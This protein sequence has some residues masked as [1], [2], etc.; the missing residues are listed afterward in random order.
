MEFQAVKY[1]M[2]SFCMAFLFYH[3]SCVVLS[4]TV[5]QTSTLYPT[6]KYLSTLTGKNVSETTAA[7][8]VSNVRPEDYASTT[9]VP[10]QE[11]NVLGETSKPIPIM[12]STYSSIMSS[13]Y[14]SGPLFQ[15]NI[16]SPECKVLET[17][18][19][20]GGLSKGF[21]NKNCY[22]D[23][24]CGSRNDCCKNYNPRTN[25]T[26]KEKQYS[27]VLTKSIRNYEGYGIY[28]VTSCTPPTVNV[29]TKIELLF[30][31]NM[32]QFVELF[33]HLNYKS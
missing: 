16:D 12:S 5:N 30:L 25:L 14:T 2:L 28:M 18:T 1:A 10:F 8:K 29:I 15:Y 11:G 17:C 26:L 22:C 31:T 20:T 13:T 4:S 32:I 7:F 33:L 19:D 27:C 21:P 9:L 23:F 3:K 24:A 6:T